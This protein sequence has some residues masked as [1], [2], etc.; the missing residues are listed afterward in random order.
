MVYGINAGGLKLDG[1]YGAKASFHT[2]GGTTEPTE[3]LRRLRNLREMANSRRDRPP[4]R[5]FNDFALLWAMAH[6]QVDQ[7]ILGT[8][9]TA[10]LRESLERLRL[11]Q[12]ED[13][14]DVLEG[15]RSIRQ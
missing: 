12:M 9:R 2:R 8:S 7:V 4:L 1:N 6:P 14:A 3:L 5:S 13:Y 11:F 10:Q 15:L